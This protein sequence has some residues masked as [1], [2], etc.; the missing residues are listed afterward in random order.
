MNTTTKLEQIKNDETYKQVLKDSFGGVL[1]N[2]ANRG[3]YD[4]TGLL[5][6]WDSLSP[7]ER[8]SVGGIMTGAINFLEG[9]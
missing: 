9:N 3:K 5:A 2:V 4:A 1:Y 8:E 6:L 7:A